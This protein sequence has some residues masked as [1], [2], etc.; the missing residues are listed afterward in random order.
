MHNPP[1][2]GAVLKTVLG[3]TPIAVSEAA[4]K[5]NISRSLLSAVVNGRKPVRAE[6]AM[7]LERAGLSTACFW[8]SMQSIYD[9]WKAEQ[10]GYPEVG[11]ITAV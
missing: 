11:R 3:A 7:R 1:H 4:R 8:L 9:Q 2:P 5:L 10:I 6:L